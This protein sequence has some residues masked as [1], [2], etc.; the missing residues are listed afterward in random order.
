MILGQPSLCSK[1]SQCWARD[2][3]A[4]LK[5]RRLCSHQKGPWNQG[6]GAEVCLCRIRQTHAAHNSLHGGDRNSGQS[7]PSQG[8]Y[9]TAKF[10]IAAN[11]RCQQII[12]HLNMPPSSRGHGCSDSAAHAARD[13]VWHVTAADMWTSSAQHGPH[14]LQTSQCEV[15]RSLTSFSCW[16]HSLQ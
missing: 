12:D 16:V 14:V 7:C 5:R 11:P 8:E 9:C 1:W 13:S 6:S 2:V 4:P 10:W 3:T 15:T